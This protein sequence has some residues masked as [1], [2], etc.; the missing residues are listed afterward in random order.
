M[1]MT[2]PDVMSYVKDVMQKNLAAVRS[3][4]VYENAN[5]IAVQD[6][7]AANQVRIADLKS[8]ESE[9]VSH[10]HANGWDETEPT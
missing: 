9:L 3:E 6:N 8:K 10:I 5:F 2:T 1:R 7:L 4:L